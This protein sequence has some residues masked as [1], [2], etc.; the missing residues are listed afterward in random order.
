M[1]LAATGS[2]T[3][4]LNSPNTVVVAITKSSTLSMTLV[5][6]LSA[7]TE[8]K[9]V[10]NWGTAPA[11][12]DLMALQYSGANCQVSPA[13]GCTGVTHDLASNAGGENGG[14]IIT[15]STASTPFKYMIFVRQ[16]STG[17]AGLF[18]KSQVTTQ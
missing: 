12:L 15:W 1:A 13:G 8:F 10:L 7:T 16:V 11:D 18:V 17:A 4:Y 5:P 6:S 9:A 14:E 3:G 2:K